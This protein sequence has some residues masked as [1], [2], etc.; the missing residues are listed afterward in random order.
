[1]TT[2]LLV[3]V[4]NLSDSSLILVNKTVVIR[5]RLGSLNT[6]CATFWRVEC[7]F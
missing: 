7:L 2:L 6:R 3:K 4:F 5:S 1:M